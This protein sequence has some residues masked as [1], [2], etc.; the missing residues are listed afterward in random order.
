MTGDPYP[1]DDD[2]R[3]L[4]DAHALLAA[5]G[6]AAG[7]GGHDL[8]ALAAAVDARGWAYGIDRTAGAARL[9]VP[10][11]AAGPGG[12]ARAAVARVAPARPALTTRNDG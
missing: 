10:R 9:A 8:A 2:R 4:A 12:T 3:A 7:P 11:A 6:V 1:D 5:G